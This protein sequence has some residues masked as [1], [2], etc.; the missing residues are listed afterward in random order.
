VD[1]GDDKL[2]G[3]AWLDE[4]NILFTESMDAFP[5]AGYNDL[6]AFVDGTNW[7][8]FKH[9][10]GVLGPDIFSIIHGR[11]QSV[12]EKTYYSQ[13]PYRLGCD[14]AMKFKMV[15]NGGPTKAGDLTRASKSYTLYIQTRKITDPEVQ[16]GTSSWSTKYVAVADLFVPHQQMD[17]SNKMLAYSTEIADLLAASFSVQESEKPGIHKMFVFHPAITSDIHQP[18]GPINSFRM[19]FYSQHAFTRYDTYLKPLKEKVAHLP[20]IMTPAAWKAIGD[21][22]SS[23]R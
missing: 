2:S 7:E 14:L 22:V 13:L 19:H 5:M 20:L 15:S 18:L 6:S 17:A 1:C 4:M 11:V 8:S 21:L 3:A 9:A 23:K 12:L 10:A 16:V